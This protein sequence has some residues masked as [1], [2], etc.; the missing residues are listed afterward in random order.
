[1]EMYTNENMGKRKLVD[2]AIQP[3][4]TIAAVTPANFVIGPRNPAY[5]A[6]ILGDYKGSARFLDLNKLVNLPLVWAEQQHILG[7]LDGREEGYDL[8]TLTVANG[9]VL[10]TAYSGSLTVPSGEVWYLNA[11]Q[12]VLD[13]TASAHGLT[14]NWRC[15]IWPDRAATPSP[16]GQAFYAANLVRAAGGATTWLA[17][18]GPIATAW[19]IT[20]KTVLLRLPAGTVITLAI[21][22]TTA[23]ATAAVANTLMLKGF[24]TEVLVD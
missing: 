2:K 5:G 20:N 22:T 6:V 8:R 4:S 1:M 12:V 23:Q 7:I 13:T 21:A 15:S 3:M 19:L 18:F 14:G 10:G 9:A 24:R 11:V 16:D 17:E